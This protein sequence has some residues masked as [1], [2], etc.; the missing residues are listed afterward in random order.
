MGFYYARE[1][2]KFDQEWERL[3][4]EYAQA[5]MSESAIEQM[6]AFD[7]RWFCSCR[8]YALHN[9]QL[10]DM[11]TLEVN[12]SSVLVHL[13]AKMSA[14]SD[15]QADMDCNS[16]LDTVS[17]ENLYKRL[18]TLKEADL[19]LLALI[20]LDGYSQADVARIQGCSRN[21]INK[22]MKRIR[23]LLE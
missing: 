17:D 16:W 21:A 8:V 2:R 1:K 22:R 7:W 10:P 9:Q 5:G 19:E 23:R 15:V 20:V 12:G 6:R 11:E 18:R 4:K 3:A 14:L 13:F